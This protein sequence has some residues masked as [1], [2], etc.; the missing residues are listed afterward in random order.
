[1]RKIDV[2][3]HIFP[4][5]YVDRMKDV[6]PSFKDVGKRVRGVPMLVDLNVRLR[7]MDAHPEYQ[8]ILSIATPP[9]E[10]YASPEDAIDLAQLANDGMADLVDRYP[11]RFPGFV[12][13]LPMNDV[14]AAMRELERSMGALGARGIQVCSNVEGRALDAPEFQRC[15]PVRT[16]AI[17]QP[18]F[19]RAIA[20]QDKILAQHADG[21]RLPPDPVGESRRPPITAQQRAHARVRPD[22]GQQFVVI[23]L[24]RYFSF[25]LS[26]CIS[27]M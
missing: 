9:V 24:H 17:E 13:S 10:A 25:A 14:D 12:A 22:P 26:P 7:I 8:Q 21:H 27:N 23:Q 4:E 20:E 1:M 2:F 6:A 11:E 18:D 3:N 16:G 5:R 19:S 15:A